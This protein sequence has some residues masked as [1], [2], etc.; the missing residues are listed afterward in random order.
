M[1]SEM[2]SKC[3]IFFIFLLLISNVYAEEIQY[4]PKSFSGFAGLNTKFN[5]AKIGDFEASD[6]QNVLINLD[7]SIEKRLGC[8]LRKTFYKTKTTSFTTTTQAQ[9]ALGETSTNID[10]TTSAGTISIK[11]NWY[12]EQTTQA[13]WMAGTFT[14]LD[15][16]TSPGSLQLSSKLTVFDNFNDGDTSD[17]TVTTQDAH[18]V[19]DTVVEGAYAFEVTQPGHT[20]KSLA[21]STTDDYISFHI[22]K[23][24]NSAN[25]VGYIYIMDSTDRTVVWI[26]FYEDDLVYRDSAAAYQ[27]IIAACAID[28]WYDI[29]L[30]NINYTLDTFDVWVDDVEKVTDAD[31]RDHA[32][33]NFKKL[34]IQ[35]SWT[36][37]SRFY[38]DDIRYMV[39]GV[40][41]TSDTHTSQI[42]DLGSV[43]TTTGS[44]TNVDSHPTPNDT[45]V[46]QQRHGTAAGS[47]TAWVHAS[48]TIT[49]PSS[50]RYWE[51]K[52]LF[53]G[54]TTTTPILYSYALQFSYPSGATAEYVS[55]KFN[56][57]PA[58]TTTIPVYFSITVSDSDITGGTLTYSQ[59]HGMTNAEVNAA[60]WTEVEDGDTITTTDTMV[61]WKIALET[62]EETLTPYIYDVSINGAGNVVKGAV[63]GLY[64]YRKKDGSTYMLV[65][66]D[67]SVYSA[68][69]D[70]TFT[71]LVDITANLEMCFITI[72]DTQG[73]DTVVFC[74]GT[75]Y[76][77]AWDGTTLNTYTVAT[78]VKPNE[79]VFH[80]GRIFGTNHSY[81]MRLYYSYFFDD[82]LYDTQY[83][84]VSIPSGEY[85]SWLK[86]QTRLADDI[87]SY[88]LLGSQTTTWALKNIASSISSGNLFPI[89]TEVG[90]MSHFANTNIEGVQQFPSKKGVMNFD[91]NSLKNIGDK[92]QPDYEDL[93]QVFT[94]KAQQIT[95]T[96]SEWQKGTTK[97]NIDMTTTVGSLQID[98]QNP[99]SPITNPSFESGIADSW[100]TVAGTN[101]TWSTD[102]T[103]A[104]EGNS[105]AL[106][107][108]LLVTELPS[109]FKYYVLSETG[110]IL[111]TSPATTLTTTWTKFL[112]EISDYDSNDTI[113]LRFRVYISTLETVRYGYITSDNFTAFSHDC[114]VWVYYLK[115]SPTH[116]CWIDDIQRYHDTATYV[117]A[118]HNTSLD[119]PYYGIFE[120][121]YDAKGQTI[122]FSIRTDTDGLGMEERTWYSVTDGVNI[123]APDRRYNQFRIE[124]STGDTSVSPTVNSVKINYGV[125]T[126]INEA[127]LQGICWDD[128][129][130]L[131]G[132]EDGSTYNNVV[133]AW[134]YKNGEWTKFKG[135]N[136]NRWITFRNNL[137]FGSSTEAKIYQAWVGKN[138]DGETITAH[139]TSKAYNFGLPYQRKRLRHICMTI[140]T[141]YDEKNLDIY[142]TT[143]DVESS[144]VDTISLYSAVR[145]RKMKILSID[146]SGYYHK[147]RFEQADK[148]ISF[149]MYEFLLGVIPSTK[150]KPNIEY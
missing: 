7:G 126:E 124:M 45:I 19:S 85:L 69:D 65:V 10:T 6:L 149:K 128:Y 134:N 102:T 146:K 115:E 79:M 40:Y 16:E 55:K 97:T 67:T 68:P 94:Q 105:S 9:F 98:F 49:L 21:S 116:R 66:I 89:F 58:E 30:K 54:N 57:T 11:N 39:E 119:S 122:T 141:G 103:Y 138:D 92:I 84:L 46:Y 143:D 81:P 56:I 147:I 4:I 48:N 73:N 61:Q 52:S 130:L 28:T 127:S 13:D 37:G 5:D 125:N 18:L 27:V 3:F 135:W 76:R 24:N 29:E 123:T 15:T 17:W 50:Y 87:T 101:A 1:G 33:T 137:Y 95:T 110:A 91:G 121:D 64:E 75:D 23:A 96:Q 35:N 109:I 133:Y 100:T 131:V 31:M 38:T 63:F 62:D 150:L 107:T 113:A 12:K 43:P 120:A 71:K 83:L 47:W 106:W 145:K 77:F 36:V 25:H 2:K 112:I 42:L 53:T 132:A 108:Q 99:D 22:R 8:I 32:A 80:Q 148:D 118:V 41:E 26:G 111:Y 142:Y 51:I 117:S 136:V 139:W 114:S 14:Y 60:S 129:Y 72:S 82:L 74:N 59:R 78:Q 93:G 140:A 44:F 86:P 70:S 90:S 34:M 88:L 104:H 144:R 20:H